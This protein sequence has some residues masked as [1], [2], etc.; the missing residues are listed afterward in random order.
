MYIYQKTINNRFKTLFIN[1]ACLFIFSA[2][3]LWQEYAQFA[4]GVLELSKV[5]EILEKGLSAA[6][7]H[8]ASGSLLWDTLRELEFAHFSAKEPQSE[9][10][11]S[12]LQRLYDIFKR[13]LS[14]PLLGMESTYEEF[15]Q[16]FE[17][18]PEGHGLEKKAVTWGYE[19]ALKALEK[20]KP[21]EDRFL[22]AQDENEIHHIYKEYIKVVSDPSLILN[23]YERAVAQLSLNTD[24]WADYCT[25]ALKLGE[26]SLSVSS[27]AL[28][29]CPWCEE[30]WILRLRILEKQQA[31]STEIMKQFE[32]GI[33]CIPPPGLELWLVYI[34]YV[35]RND[36]ST[37]KLHKLCQQAI[38]Q[39]G[40]EGDPAC[41]LLRW[42]ARLF[43]AE[44]KLA[45][46]RK[47]WGEILKNRQH[48]E[49]AVAWLEYIALERRYG[50][51]KQLRVLF[52]RAINAC[53]DWPQHLMEEWLMF[54]RE[55]G[56]L[57]DVLKCV[58]KSRELKQS[59]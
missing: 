5:R 16:W 18:L 35:R 2:V 25:Y 52:Q 23:L 59:K 27:R 1:R 44:G 11:R 55:V 15:E 42:Q 8:V 9:E 20:Y 47:N 58:E 6:G 57:E 21:F 48:R 17:Q 40:Y 7:M 36:K 30:L 45:E 12:Q 53:K 51:D 38:E 4:I 19:R 56:S 29:N 34:E 10:W 24:L 13:Q 50:D 37:E 43:A 26:I 14:V 46:A 3:E 22:I 41:K 28:R 54:E 31:E 49:S 39:I 33:S 32:Q